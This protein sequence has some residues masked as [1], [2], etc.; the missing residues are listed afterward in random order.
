[1]KSTAAIDIM[2]NMI[3]INH[4]T[5]K[6]LEIYP[7]LTMT[8]TSNNVEYFSKN[9]NSEVDQFEFKKELP[10]SYTPIHAIYPFKNILISCENC[11]G[12]IR[13]NS[14][15]INIPILME[16]EIFYNKEFK[17]YSLVYED[18][19]K[20]H[21][22]NSKTLTEIQLYIISKLDERSKNNQKVDLSCVNNSI[23]RLLP[24]T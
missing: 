21:S 3:H 16:H 10:Q 6:L 22:L 14:N 18:L 20:H 17:W 8:S 15:C 4:H 19:I 2:N 7:D 23:R 1:M 11:N 13:V 5:K 24:F 9:I 12:I